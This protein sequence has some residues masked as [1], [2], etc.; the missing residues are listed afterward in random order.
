M[1]L[2]ESFSLAC[3]VLTG[4]E[5]GFKFNP[6]LHMFI[7]VQGW[8]AFSFTSSA[9]QANSLH[10]A[11]VMQNLLKYF[12]LSNTFSPFLF[13]LKTF[14]VYLR[15]SERNNKGS[16]LSSKSIGHGNSSSCPAFWKSLCVSGQLTFLN[17]V[18]KTG[19]WNTVLL[20]PLNESIWST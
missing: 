18:H 15:S 6:T 5:Y 17:N 8:A 16:V 1:C 4:P 12:I 2:D 20:D 13:V 19:G 7:V 14:L 9:L 10:M 11:K 3:H